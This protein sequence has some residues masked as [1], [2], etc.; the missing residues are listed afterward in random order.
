MIRD[1]RGGDVARE[2]LGEV[3]G[4]LVSDRW[5]GY[6][7]WPLAWRQACWSHIQRDFQA[8]VDSHDPEAQSI[9]RSLLKHQKHLV[10]L[11]H[12]V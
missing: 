5:S 10:K 1:S 4:V 12:R 3:F 2:I 6:N 11:W 8:F 9:G 7:W